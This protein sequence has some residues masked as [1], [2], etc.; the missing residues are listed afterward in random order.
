MR[1]FDEKNVEVTG[2]QQT[3]IYTLININFLYLYKTF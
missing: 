2:L 3:P 1:N